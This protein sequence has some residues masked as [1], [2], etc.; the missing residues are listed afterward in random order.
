MDEQDAETKQE[1][2]DL[3]VVCLV[4]ALPLSLLG[5]GLGLC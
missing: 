1:V 3:V 2:A 4:L 5:P